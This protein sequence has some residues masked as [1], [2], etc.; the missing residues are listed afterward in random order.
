[1]M[2]AL[3]GKEW[4]LLLRDP[5]G[6]G[7]LFAMPT[8]FILIMSL[9]MQ[10]AFDSGGGKP[11]QV[12]VSAAQAGDMGDKVVARLREQTATEVVPESE[13]PAFRVV[14]PADFGQRLFQPPAE[15][16]GPLFK[17][18]GDPAVLPQTRAA[19]RAALVGAVLHVQGNA[20]IATMESQQDSDLSAVRA[21][22]DPTQWRIDDGSQAGTPLPS[23]VQ[24]SVPGWLVFAMFFVVVPLSTVLIV[25]REQGTALRLRALQVPAWK[26]LLARVPAYFIVNMLQMAAMLAVGVWLVPAIGGDAL[27]LG[28]HPA[29]LL[30]VG[31]ATSLAAVGFAM[32]VAVIARTSVQAI[33]LGGTFNLVFGAVGGIMV[34]KM[35]MPAALQTA[36]LASPMSW[37]LEGFWDIVLRRGTPLDALPECAVLAGFGLASLGV[38]IILHTRA[39]E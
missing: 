37:A 39:S 10:G 2:G 15:R 7:V 27:S 19:F 33:A 17:W 11:M 4:R 14:L 32:L 30:L 34:P 1:M 26:L 22:M 18:S 13:S 31:S 25:E 21:A 3:A 20:L 5:H 16:D 6:L 12:A 8:L 23:A 28:D 24:Q 38:A 9:A 36:A 35:V 29:G